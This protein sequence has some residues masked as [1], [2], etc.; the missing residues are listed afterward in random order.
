MKLSLQKKAIYMVGGILLFALC[1]NT[2]VLTY[3]AAGKYRTAILSKSEA[4][5]EGLHRELSKVLN[6]GVPIESLEGVNEKLQDMVQRNASFGYV[7]VVSEKGK[8]LFHN[9]AKAVG[10]EVQGVANLKP[11]SV[12]VGQ[13]VAVDSFYELVFPLRNAENKVAGFLHVGVKMK[14]IQMQIYVLLIWALGISLFCFLV[15]LALVYTLMSR[16]ITS[17]ILLMERAAEKISAG[18][19]TYTFDVHGDDELASL[20]SAIKR[21]TV[22]LKNIIS[23]TST[24][25]NSVSGATA[26]IDS[27]AQLLRQIAQ[28]QKKAVEDTSLSARDMSTSITEVATSSTSLFD[29]ASRTSS[30]VMEMTSLVD[31]IAKNATSFNEIANETASSIEEMISTIKQISESVGSLSSASTEMA[32]SLVQVNAAT[33]S[34]ENRVQ[35]SVVLARGVSQNATEKGMQAAL[36]AQE[37]MEKIK[38]NVFSLSK[39]IS[40]LGGRMDDIGKTLR[41]ISDITDQTNLLALN[42]AILASRAGEHG[43][44]FSVVAREIKELSERASHSTEEIRSL[45]VEIQDTTKSSVQ[46]SDESIQAVESGI[47]LSRDVQEALNLI[48]NSARESTEMAK[49]IEKATEEEVGALKHI[50]RSME[51]MS[52]QIDMISRALN[53][54]TKG[55]NFIIEATEKVRDMS[56]QVKNSTEEQKLGSKHILNAAENVTRESSYLENLVGQQR[57][58]SSEIVGAMERIKET[59]SDLVNAA[60]QMSEVI[61]SLKSDS[62]YLMHELKRFKV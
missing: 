15:S 32:S 37:G 40:H 3:I 18:E 29:T 33:K 25:S 8:V 10:T 30:V 50:T 19:L 54:Q 24:I 14:D 31:S 23:N 43:K 11:E 17:P 12:R 55:S 5:G 27:S 13:A 4:I 44:G 9:D 39:V 61:T 41:V 1:I 56:L 21:M 48:V 7:R 42:A 45:V 58:K 53:E 57:E 38:K 34:I 46:M 51:Q 22:N 6:L 20:G 2:A 36:A 16:F 49:A 59:T 52:G 26:K 60:N 28:I 35:E 47:L 62:L